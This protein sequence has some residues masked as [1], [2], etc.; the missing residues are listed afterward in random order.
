[1]P[2]LHDAYWRHTNLYLSIAEE[3][4]DLFN[5]NARQE[6]GLLV[7]DLN[8]DQINSALSWLIELVPADQTDFLLVQ[9]V[10]ALSAIGMVRYSAREK[11]IPLYE[12]QIAATQR[13]SIKELEANAIDGLGI[14]YAYLGYLPRA[15]DCFECAKQIADETGDKELRQDIQNHVR[16]AHKQMGEKGT[17]TLQIAK[18]PSVLRLIPAW[19]S[20]NLAHLKRDRFSEI[21]SLNR[22]ANLHLVL[23][24]WDS[25]IIYF[26]RAISLSQTLSYRFGQLEASMG[27][28]EAEMSRNA[29]GEISSVS[30]LS[31]LS[32]DFEW[33]VDEQVLEALIEIAP[34][35]DHLEAIANYLAQKNAPAANEIYQ[36]LDQIMLQ[37]ER[38]IA[39]SAKTTAQKDEIFLTSLQI[40]KEN[41]ANAVKTT[42]ALKKDSSL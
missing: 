4:N 24:K 12:C 2:S 29:R 28:L 6:K 26:Q 7:F 42:S 15:I 17:L 40:I 1:M 33:G 9:F 16:L 20:L 39:T 3:A 22:I 10:D 41:L 27:L 18:I 35:I 25:A 21:T 37:T 11:L 14:L 32:S 38:I 31:D 34:A 23:E 13:L 8:S 5:S 36:Y 19:I 30:E